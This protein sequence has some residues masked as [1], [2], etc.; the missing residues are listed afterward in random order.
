MRVER[1]EDGLIVEGCFPD[2]EVVNLIK[3]ECGPLPLVICD[4]PYG[5][6]VEDVWDRTKMTDVQ[7]S[8]WMLGWTREIGEICLPASALYVWAG[9]GTPGFRPFYKY[10]YEVEKLTEYTIGNHITWSKRRAYGTATNYLFTREELLYLVKGDPK[11]PRLFN[12]PLLEEKRGYAGFSAKYPAKSEFLRRT[13]VWGDINEL[14]RGKVHTAQKP[15]RLHEVLIEAHTSPGEW[16]LDPF[17]GSGTT[18]RA[19]R[20]LGRKFVLVDKDPVSFEL[21]LKSLKA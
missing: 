18:G 14:F 16:V 19:A 6:V 2:P 4:P 8:D 12:I 11:K 17:A 1:L 15:D 3:S 9:I 10:A 20:K 13:N 7:F 5:N 21:C